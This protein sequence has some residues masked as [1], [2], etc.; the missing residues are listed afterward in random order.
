MN[1]REENAARALIQ[2]FLK[3]SVPEYIKDTGQEILNSGGVHKLTI[4]KEGDT[5][6]VEGIVQGEDFQN[7]S[8]HLMLNPGDSQISYNCNCH[9]AFMGV[10]RHVA[11]TALKMFADLDKDYGAPEEPQRL[12][13][14]WRQ[15][16]RS[17]FSSSLEPETGRHY[18]IFRFYPEPGRL[19]VA[20]FRARQNKT[21]LSSVHQERLWSRSCAIPSGA[22]SLPSSCRSPAR[23]AT[24]S[25]TTGTG[26]KFR[27]ASFRG[28]SGPSA[29]NTTCSGR[30]RTSH[31]PS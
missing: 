12:N 15:S 30:T 26:S 2:G 8:P 18:F 25:T 13:T 14:E 19:I 7:Y 27:K 16:F 21:G 17:F 28:S 1:V 20:L 4:R 31:A 3:D 10:C 9:E 23:S 29:A 11:A 5:W 6:D 24:T 22:I